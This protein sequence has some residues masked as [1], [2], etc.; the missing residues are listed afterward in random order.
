MDKFY[1]IEELS[2]LLHVKRS[3]IYAWTHYRKVPYIKLGK[4]LLFDR[5]EIHDWL[6]SKH[7]SQKTA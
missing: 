3:T 7:V 4:H 2:Q 5:E 1:T 6:A